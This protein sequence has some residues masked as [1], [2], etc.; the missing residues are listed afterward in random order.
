MEQLMNSGADLSEPRHVLFY[1][2]ATSRETADAM[3]REAGEQG[4]QVDLREP[5]PEFPGQWAVVCEVKAVLSPD[6]VRDSGDFFDR[7]TERHRAEYDG[8]EAAV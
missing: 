6:F 1:C 5:L 8:W 7:L 4:F 3:A 2:Y